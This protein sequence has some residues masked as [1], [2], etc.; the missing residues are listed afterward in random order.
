[1]DEIK[2]WERIRE[3]AEST[4]NQSTQTGWSKNSLDNAAKEASSI[5]KAQEELM[6][7]EVARP[8]SNFPFVGKCSAIQKIF[9]L[10]D[11]V[12]DTDSTILVLGESGTGKELVARALHLRSSRH[13]K[14]FIP[15]NCGAIPSELLETELFG[16]VKGAYTGAHTSRVGRF[17]LANHGTLFLDEVGTMPIN[18]Q[19]KIL[20]A[21]QEK[22]Y[23]PVGGSK[24]LK[25]DCRVIAA[26][27]IDLEQEVE[28]GNFREDLFYR[29]NVIPIT[30]PPLRER[31]EDIPSLI[32][33]FIHRYNQKKKFAIDGVSPEA[34]KV[35]IRYPWP[36]NVRELENICQRLVILKG[37]GT[38]DSV[39]LP[40]KIHQARPLKNSGAPWAQWI[41]DGGFPEEGID[42]DGVVT[43][44]ENGLILKALE[45]TKWNKNKAAQKLKLNRTTLVEKIK[46]RGL[47]PA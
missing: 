25:S 32:Q 19:V 13:N 34:M 22:E 44:F 4:E 36:G 17:S 6:A 29:L 26:S 24:T 47:T 16:H 21:L 8:L 3:E 23:E 14:P 39:D 45:Q 2:V 27:N 46:K 15:I 20:R 35:L 5:S 1:M 43:Q 33:Y 11:K 30:L 12:A 18:L 9:E 37:S 42:F 40:T 38:I 41:G 7:L 10:I 28:K 31:A